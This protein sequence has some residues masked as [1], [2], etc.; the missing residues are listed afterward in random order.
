MSAAQEAAMSK[1]LWLSLGG[2]LGTF[3]R[4]GMGLW[5]PGV[6]GADFPYATLAI[7]LTACLLIGL[8]QG[9][10][11]RGALGP[12]GRLLLMTGF[13]GAYSTFSTLILESGNLAADGQAARALVNYLGSG[14][15]G[16]ILF[17]LGLRLG[18]AI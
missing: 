5:V 12:D 16:F 14:A 9:L 6:A 2:I 10:G 7:N 3:A 13:C 1:W 8:F 15:G 18:G 11:A 17:R 4:Y